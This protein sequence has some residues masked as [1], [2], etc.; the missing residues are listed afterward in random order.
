M[1]EELDLPEATPPPQGGAPDPLSIEPDPLS[2]EP[3]PLSIEPD[4]L[5]IEPAPPAA[6]PP[7]L[8][9]GPPAPPAA[10]PEPVA[11]DLGPEPVPPPLAP[12]DDEE[13]IS[14][15]DDSERDEDSPGISM[16]R[17]RSGLRK[18]HEVTLNRPLNLTG[19][20]ATRCRIF[21]CRIAVEALENMQ[22]RI[23]EW[24]DN[25]EIEV[26]HVGQELAIM[27]GKTPRPNLV[28]TVWY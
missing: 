6:E 4:P 17:Q 27:E 24:I 20:G 25:D 5:S 23:N 3:D 16:V 26:K 11:L 22:S 8:A 15:V 21:Y 12:V 13:P 2:I 7:P 18:A 1:P 14:L 10:G 9:A 19:T 28:V